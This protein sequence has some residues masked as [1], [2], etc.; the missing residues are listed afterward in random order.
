MANSIMERICEKRVE[1]G[2][3]ELAIYN[4]ERLVMLVWLL[5]CKLK[6]KNLINDTLLQRISSCLQV[7][8]GFLV[9]DKTMVANAVLN[10]LCIKDLNNINPRSFLP[11][12]GMNSMSAIEI[13]QTLKREYEI[14]LTTTDIRNLNLVKLLDR[15]NNLTENSN[16]NENETNQLKSIKNRIEGYANAFKTLESKIKSP[17]TCFQFETNY[18]L[19][20]VKAMANSFLPIDGAFQYLKT[21][22]QENLHLSSQE[23]L[24]NNILLDIMNA[25]VNVNAI[26]PCYKKRSIANAFNNY[27]EVGNVNSESSKEDAI[28]GLIAYF[29]KYKNA[30]RLEDN[31]FNRKD[32]ITD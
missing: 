4:G 7:L 29:P 5:M 8:N 20:T 14:Y 1:E 3:P 25:Y 12:L 26:E 21:F 11:E 30:E 19:K 24:K 22:I 13:K 2:L 32:H 18:E 10:I 28:S 17:A 15:N 16:P 6:I 27:K 23:E 9:Q 31:L